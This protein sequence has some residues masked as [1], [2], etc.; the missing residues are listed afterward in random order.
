MLIRTRLRP[1]CFVRS[2]Q[3]S[4]WIGLAQVQFGQITGVASIARA[5]L[6][7]DE[8]TFSA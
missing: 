6:F 1:G 3:L 4:L 2:F 7:R 5:N 8:L